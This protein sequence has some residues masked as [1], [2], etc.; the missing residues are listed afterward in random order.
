MRSLVPI[1]AIAFLTTAPTAFA[2]QGPQDMMGQGGMWQGMMTCDHMPMMG[3]MQSGQHIEGRIAFLKAELK[4]TE[5]QMPQWDAYAAALRANA[6]R[7]QALRA[8]MMS[9]GMMGHGMMSHGQ[10][11]KGPRVPEHLA[12]AEQHMA[13]HMEMLGEIKGPLSDLY[14]VFNDEQKHLADELL[15]GIMG[16]M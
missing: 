1:L 5:A 3:G 14:G 8:E 15:M 12:W 2:Q 13:A 6:T 11:G 4:I 7:M 10:A 9:N 16:M